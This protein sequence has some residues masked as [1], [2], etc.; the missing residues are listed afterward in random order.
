M[1]KEIFAIL[2]I[3][4]VL[5][6]SSCQ[7]ETVDLS[8]THITKI[9]AKVHTH[10]AFQ[11]NNSFDNYLTIGKGSKTIYSLTFIRD[12]EDVTDAVKWKKIL[13]QPK[14]K[15]YPNKSY[16][17]QNDDVFTTYSFKGGAWI[18]I[19]KLY[20]TRGQ[21]K[22]NAI[23]DSTLTMNIIG[24]LKADLLEKDTVITIDILSDTL[25]HFSP[26]SSPNN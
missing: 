23:T 11:K 7:Q 13:I 5:I 14:E 20:A 19:E 22:V 15:L 4:T 9:K 8:E 24:A 26:V 12:I 18:G 3:V 16:Y 10:S 6:H 17:L 2:T 1:K 25:V 21:I